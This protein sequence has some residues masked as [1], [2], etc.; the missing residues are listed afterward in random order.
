VVLLIH[1]RYTYKP[2]VKCLASGVY[3]VSVTFVLSAGQPNYSDRFVILFSFVRSSVKDE[4]KPPTFL[5]PSLLHAACRKKKQ[6]PKFCGDT[7]Q[8]ASPW[9]HGPPP[10]CAFMAGVLSDTLLPWGHSASTEILTSD[11]YAT[12]LEFP[13]LHPYSIN[14]IMTLNPAFGLIFAPYIKLHNAYSYIWLPVLD[15][16][17]KCL[18]SYPGDVRYYSLLNDEVNFWRIT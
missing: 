3:S 15:R 1:V 13:N 18:A 4:I 16:L 2:T 7:C 11:R 9:S 6:H 14:C 8:A 10:F 12:S 5:T 17:W